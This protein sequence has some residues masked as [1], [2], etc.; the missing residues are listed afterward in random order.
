MQAV[1]VALLKLVHRICNHTIGCKTACVSENLIEIIFDLIALC[2][3][4]A[5]EL[6]EYR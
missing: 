1:V 5:V 3:T 2:R 6:V 4:Y